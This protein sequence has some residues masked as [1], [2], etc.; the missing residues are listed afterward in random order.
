MNTINRIAIFAAAAMALAPAS[1]YAQSNDLLKVE[2]CNYYKHRPDGTPGRVLHLSYGSL[3]AGCVVE[4]ASRKGVEKAQ[5]KPSDKGG[6]E[7]LLNA[8]LGVEQ[9]DTV[10][11]TLKGAQLNLRRKV[12]VA[13]MRH[14]DVYIYPHS[15]VDIGYTNTQ[16]NVEFIHKRN[17]DVAI[18]LANATANYPKEAQFRWNPEV[19]W[20]VERYLGSATPD[21]KKRL[22][23][24]IKQGHIA[25]DAGYINTNTSACSDEELLE[26][27]RNAKQMERLTGKS[28]QIFVQVDIPGV[29]WGLVSAASQMGVKYVLSLFNGGDR[30]GLSP[31][32]SFRPFW[33]EGPDGKSRV[34]FMQP[35]S[36]APGA[37][38]KGKFYWPKMAGQT[39][40]SKLID[41][42]RTDNP[43]E[44]FI[45]GYLWQM[46]E[47]LQAD[48]EY[49][50]DVFPMTWCMADNTPVD[51]DLPDAVRS[52]NEEY[53]YPRLH[54]CTATEMMEAFALR[55]AD[56]IPVKQGDF[57][58]YWT[59]GLGSSAAKTG[60]SREVKEKLVQAD[61]LWSMLREQDTPPRNT[62]DEAWRNMLL[63]TEHTWAYMN[64]EQEP[65][66][67]EIL[68]RK[69]GYF[70]TAE[71]LTDEL[72]AMALAK[73]RDDDSETVAVFNTNSWE[74]TGIV[75]L[76]PSEVAGYV[77]VVDEAGNQVP[78]QFAADGS[79]LFYAERV[80]ALG[81]RTFRL[82]GTAC[83]LQ[84]IAISQHRL[85]NG[86]VDVEIDPLTGDVVSL[87]R[88]GIEYVDD[89]SLSSVNSVRHLWGND[90]PG[91][92]LRPYDVKVSV[93]ECGPL[94]ASLRIV[95]QATACDSIVREV[96]ITRGSAVVECRNTV[97]KQATK[98]K[99]GLHFGF[100]F[101]VD[102]PVTRVDIPWGSMTLEKDQI[103]VANRNWIAAWRWVDVSNDKMGVTWCPMNA[104]VFESGDLT[105]RILGG[106]SGS[107]DWI[108]H[109]PQSSTIYSW[110]LNN[111]W[112]TNFPL[113]QSGTIC[114]SYRLLPHGA[115]SVGDANRF[116][117]EQFRG[118]KACRVNL[119]LK[120]G[121]MPV[122]DN[123]NVY[124]STCKTIKGGK[125]KIVRV[126]SASDK[127]E[128]L[129]LR[130]TGKAPKKL[131]LTDGNEIGGV[132]VDKSKAITVPAKGVCTI[133][134]EW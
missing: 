36:Y 4:V 57:T 69:F 51:A 23:D 109:L 99:E 93:G 26:L 129:N 114:Y 33:W 2:V 97:Y 17:L 62:F 89:R 74:Q 31:E 83:T 28:V 70:D 66:C 103:S 65:I 100:A 6:Y 14:W 87:R 48:A 130:W 1:I 30:T 59:D 79:L 29:S 64:P 71:K 22:L 94:R 123:D 115:F 34:L 122:V 63:S 72:C 55:Y 132:A 56:K 27:M 82:T 46:L 9:A 124:L 68:Q 96:V 49:P 73:V 15:H 116:G 78:S 95:S 127:A 21:K 111:H 43:R 128:Q 117:M 84:P 60:R 40:R 105:A 24:A 91:R 8:D 119:S 121:S 5:V 125:T 80:P 86:I 76:S 67:S 133:R 32:V 3:P 75:A 44:N 52:W 61:I 53:A 120:M 13:A 39:D 88:G 54:I 35:G 118:L 11:V 131:W 110:A 25:L 106:A 18:D 81:K 12:A 101:R 41:V 58:E 98:R 104:A 126:Q 107:P 50:Y 38:L 112:H 20:P 92:A 10:E 102:S 134:A 77:G 85:S 37:Q 42:V 19:M 108:R 113:S 45:D 90:T 16:E 47:R 7:V